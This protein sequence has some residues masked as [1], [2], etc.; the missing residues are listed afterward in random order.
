MARA[1]MW[2]GIICLAL[3]VFFLLWRGPMPGEGFV[4]HFAEIDAL[5]QARSMIADLHSFRRYYALG[6][7]FSLFAV[8]SIAI[9]IACWAPLSEGRREAVGNLTM[10]VAVSGALVIY[11]I[12][13][14]RQGFW[15]PISGVMRD[16]GFYPIFGHRLLFVW[17][18]TAIQRI[19]PQLSDLEAF[20]LSQCF[21]ILLAVYA[22]GHWSSLHI[23]KELSWLG[24]V[25]GAMMLSTCFSYYNPYDI[26]TVF[27]TTCGL[28]AIYTTR[29][30]WLIAVVALGTLN[31]EGVV[32][33]VL[34]AVFMAY[35]LDPLRRWLPA[36]LTSLAV[37]AGER[38][39]LQTAIPQTRS[40]D[41]RIW[42]NL[43]SIQV[44]TREM[45]ITIL[46]L[47]AWYA[48][49]LMN[50][51]N[52][53]PRLKRLLLLFPL[54]FIVTFLFGQFWEPRQFDAFIPVAVAV[55]LNSINRRLA[56]QIYT[57]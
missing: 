13:M 9:A 45:A 47:P 7:G 35:G 29:Y 18:A 56:P 24:Q 2:T 12:R 49:V 37:Y 48:F 41:W 25:M 15:L 38:L 51:Q 10:T 19:A 11:L 16:P 14:E 6:A 17:V 21:A 27:F 30:W 36:V 31:Y 34:L 40:V 20:L 8:G 54:L 28:I 44:F 39:G 42:S 3:G 50:L 53:K 52:C 33:V 5:D 26:G 46:A 23:S 43:I 55:I 22:L 1:S 57:R 4:Q 32:L